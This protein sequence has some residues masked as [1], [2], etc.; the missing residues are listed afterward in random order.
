[1]PQYLA[2][3]TFVGRVD[4]AKLPM[5]RGMTYTLPERYGRDLIR[6]GLVIPRPIESAPNNT[7]HES[8]PN[9]AGEDTVALPDDGQGKPLSASPPVRRS[10]RKTAPTLKPKLGQ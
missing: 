2:V 8:A 10:R 3:K 5:H 7:A 9:V 1:M 4:D 6:N